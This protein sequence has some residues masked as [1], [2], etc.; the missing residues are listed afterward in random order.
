MI[1]V[2]HTK[3]SPRR[4]WRCQHCGC[5]VMH[6]NGAEDIDPSTLDPVSEAQARGATING[7]YRLEG[8]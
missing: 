8:A 2:L 3:G 4:A 6:D 5:K 1:P 7:L